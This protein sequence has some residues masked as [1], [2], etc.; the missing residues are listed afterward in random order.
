MENE[1]TIYTYSGNVDTGILKS[2]LADLENRLAERGEDKLF[3][4]KINSILIECLQNLIYYADQSELMVKQPVVTVTHKDGGYHIHTGNMVPQE[5][6]EKMTNY[7]TKIN[8]MNKDQ[9]R[10][11]YQ[12]VLTNGQF[13]DKG[14]AGLGF[15]NIA[16]K[17]KDNKVGFKFE[18]INDQF[19][20]FNLL[21]AV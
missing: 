14:G 21:L 12:E 6:V 16:R 19:M 3:R 10:E 4:K 5:K 2:I 8:G 7:L 9:L 18:P 17:T 13:N 20:F 15:V 11:F 1:T